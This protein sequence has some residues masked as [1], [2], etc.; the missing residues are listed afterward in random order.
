MN[1]QLSSLTAP[2][3]RRRVIVAAIA[4]L[5]LG[6]AGAVLIWLAVRPAF[7]LGRAD[8]AL[9][10]YDFTSAR[11]E[12]NDYLERWPNEAGPLLLAAKLARRSDACA[13]AERRLTEL[14]QR[15]GT[16]PAS[17]LEWML[18]GAQQGDFAGEEQRLQLT[19]SQ[20][21]PEAPEI[22]EALAK[23]YKVSYRWSEA[24]MTLDWLIQ[25]S[26]EHLPALLLRGKILDH[27]RETDAA[28][29]DFRR[30]VAQAP[31]NAATHTALAEALNRLGHTREAIYHYEVAE[32]LRPGD[33]TT[34]LGLARALTDAAA[35]SE[36][37]HQLDKVLAA[38][39]NNS[40]ALVER[41]RLALR[42]SRPA[43]AEPFL[44]RAVGAAPWRRDGYQLQ[45]LALRELGRPE[46]ISQCSARLA[47]LQSED[48]AGGRLKSQA[49]TAPG[50]VAPR[51]ELW[52]WS[53]R[54]GQR[55]DALAWLTEVLR[56]DPGHAQAHAAFADYFERAGQPR[57]AALHRAAAA[58]LR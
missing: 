38:D 28:A 37:E 32:R 3:R 5:A 52:Q 42:R 41:G 26:P 50:V 57:R 15:V 39:A 54:N 10:R 48:A 18:L 14:E 25:R 44:A 7:A 16:T 58:E 46:A 23:G 8:E 13:E 20:N 43:E 55:E 51:R 11:A 29:A 19:V 2:G 35:L 53:Q 12:L 45:L 40:D 24:L 33:S 4:I 36:A 21:G 27:L 6:G 9:R 17:Q 34:L 47:E 31:E 30:A 1:R 56:L 49:V 22:V